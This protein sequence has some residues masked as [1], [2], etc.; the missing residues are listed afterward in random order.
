ML[1]LTR[2]KN[3]NS[4]MKHMFKQIK[5]IFSCLGIQVSSGTI[6][7]ANIGIGRNETNR[8]SSSSLPGPKTRWPNISNCVHV[9]SDPS[10]RRKHIRTCKAK[11]PCLDERLTD[12]GGNGS[13]ETNN[14]NANV[15]ANGRPSKVYKAS[16]EFYYFVNCEL[17]LW[18]IQVT[19][20][21]LRQVAGLE[22]RGSFVNHVFE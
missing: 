13:H 2:P 11:F 15:N 10:N 4:N 5:D 16:F 18:P 14:Q 17:S 12:R 3:Q 6:L 8:I 22:V 19:W 21:H 20:P 9:S 1:S 7:N